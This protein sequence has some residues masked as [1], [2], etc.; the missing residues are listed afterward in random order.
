MRTLCYESIQWSP[1][2]DDRPVELVAQVRAAAAAAVAMEVI[3]TEPGAEREQAVA[4]A[5]R[6]L[7]A[8]TAAL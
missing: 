8:G 7:Q 5:M 6:F 4:A 3:D 1:F 2:I